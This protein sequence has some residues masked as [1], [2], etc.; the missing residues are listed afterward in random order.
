MNAVTTKSWLETT[1]TALCIAL[2]AIALAGC[3]PMGGEA[4][5]T[6]PL[7]LFYRI[8]CPPTQAQCIAATTWAAEIEKRPLGA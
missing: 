4:S 2:L 7:N 3:K 5:A 8:F 6:K 1:G